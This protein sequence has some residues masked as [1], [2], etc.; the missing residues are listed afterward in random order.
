[1]NWRHVRLI[2]LR[3]VR[4]QLRDRRTL[5]VVAVLPL[6]LY[7]LMGM[8]ML[9]VVQFTREHATRALILGAEELPASPPLID[10]DRLRPELFPNAEGQRLLTVAQAATPAGGR[11]A[12]RERARQAV[13]G[14]ECEAVLY[15]PPGF[16]DRLDEWRA[17]LAAPSPAGQAKVAAPDL[18]QPELFF[19][20]GHERSLLTQ[21]RVAGAV[22]TWSAN[23][24]RSLLAARGLPDGV[25]LPV[26]LADAD[27]AEAGARDAAIWSKLFPFLLLIWALT[28]AFYPAVDLCAGE[29]ERGTLETLLIGPAERRDIVCGKLLTIMGFSMATAVLNLL[30]MLGVGSFVMQQVQ[31]RFGPPPPLATLWVLAALIPVSAFFSALCLALA[32]FARSAKE[33]QHYLMPLVVA[34]MPLVMLPMAPS[35]EMNLGYSLIPL[36]GVVLLLR[37]ALEGQ[38]LTAL[39]FAFPV[40]AVTCL[41][42]WLAIRWAVDQFSR[43]SVLFRESERLELS[44]WLQRMRRDRQE[45]PTIAQALLCGMLILA[46]QFFLNVA[47]APYIGRIG[48][49]QATLIGQLAA[50]A[51]PALLL[52]AMLTRGVR[53]TLLLRR[54]VWWTVPAAVALALALHPLGCWANIVVQRLYPLDE[55]V[56]AAFSSLLGGGPSLWELTIF[57]AL[58]PAACEELA[59]R[60]FVLSGLRR[61]GSKWQAVA[62][63]AFFFGAAHGIVQQ[64]IVAAFT[65]F[66]LGCIAVQ[67]GSLLPCF[68]FHL[69]H[70]VLGLLAVRWNA[71][72]ARPH[73]YW[74]WMFRTTEDGGRVYDWPVVALG[75]AAAAGLAWAFRRI[76]CF[77]T[78]EERLHDALKR[79]GRRAPAV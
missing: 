54:P 27:L 39:Q 41:G 23:V 72:L 24:G 30:S 31:G 77:C 34:A 32:S 8:G 68:A 75:C 4:D 12:A 2:W 55:G 5:F 78:K 63:A 19:D 62:V 53:Q 79:Q 16:R 69:T 46:L 61:L 11:E 76:D 29:K 6:L 18:P 25:A 74:D 20:S 58:V 60:G 44:H 9:Q 71:P 56:A 45:T 67:T 65:G 47:M 1:M 36:T 21:A 37:T 64:S 52:A 15:I 10:G 26:R 73:P 40:L 38:H 43:E 48:L 57:A 66:V 42:C 51:A 50:V 7:P 28:G 35:V 17:S 59:F 49:M 13:A 3:E 14:G 22:E 33:G 70:N